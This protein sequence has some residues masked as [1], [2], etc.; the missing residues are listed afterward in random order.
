MAFSADILAQIKQNIDVF[1]QYSYKNICF[2]KLTVCV[3]LDFEQTYNF[4]TKT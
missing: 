3:R 2:C 4:Q 1:E